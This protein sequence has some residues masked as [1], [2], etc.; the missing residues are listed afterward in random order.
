MPY[1]LEVVKFNRKS[2]ETPRKEHVGYMKA[3]F[4]TKKDA[5]SYY[6]KYNSHMRKLNAHNTYESDW[7]PQTRLMYIVRYDY[8]LNGTIPPFNEKDLPINE[9]LNQICY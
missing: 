5:C 8:M 4:K 9:N 2:D 1:V 6:D 3:K 7:D